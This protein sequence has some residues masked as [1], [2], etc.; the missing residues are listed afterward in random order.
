MKSLTK[1][2]KCYST[3]IVFETVMFL[4]STIIHDKTSPSRGIVDIRLGFKFK[5]NVSADT[6]AYCLIIYDRIIEYNPNVVQR[7]RKLSLIKEKYF[8]LFLI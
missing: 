5:E 2:T 6:I 8:F 4:Q 3:W 7:L 1:H